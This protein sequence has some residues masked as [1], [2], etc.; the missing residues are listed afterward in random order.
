M[1][2][3]KVATLAASALLS[4]AAFG[5]AQ[6]GTQSGAQDPSYKGS[7]PVQEVE[8]QGEAAEAQQYQSL[9]KVSL[10]EAV[11]AAQTAL[12]STAAPSKA[13]LSVENG[14]LVWE[15]VIG[16]QEVKVDAGNAQVL[17]KEAVGGEDGQE[18]GQEDGK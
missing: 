11:K 16:D 9:A 17:H 14:Y 2:R 7:I 10:Q 15:V 1:T 8:G 4:L 6:Q 5:F 13:Q 18:D 3:Y 12:S